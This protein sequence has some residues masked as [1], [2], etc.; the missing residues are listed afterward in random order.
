MQIWMCKEKGIAMPLG[1]RSTN[2]QGQMKNPYVLGQLYARNLLFTHINM[3]STLRG[4]LI[5]SRPQPIMNTVE[6]I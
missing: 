3:F 5:W 6:F 4:H 2:R 1:R